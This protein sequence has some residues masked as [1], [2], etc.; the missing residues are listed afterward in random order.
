[1]QVND[2]LNV[3]PP[4]QKI[5]EDSPTNLYTDDWSTVKVD[6][7]RHLFGKPPREFPNAVNPADTLGTALKNKII[8][9]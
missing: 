4:T 1:M 9:E 5:K 2:S 6:S 7:I 8:K 3:K